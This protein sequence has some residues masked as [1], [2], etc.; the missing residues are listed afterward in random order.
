[1]AQEQTAYEGGDISVLVNVIDSTGAHVAATISTSTTRIDGFSTVPT[2]TTVSTGIY[3]INF[4]SVTPAPSEGD[5]L[6]VKVNGDISGTAWSEY[7]IP[8]KIVAD[9]RGTD[10]ASTFDAST[11]TVTTDAASRTASQA[12]VSSLA[13]SAALSG[14]ESKIDTV[15][16]NVDSILIDVGTD[17]PASIAAL[18]DF[19]PATQ[20]VTTDSASRNASKA[21][22]SSLATAASI[23][24]L[25]DISAADVWSYSTR[26][27][28]SGGITQA[29]V[30]AA[31]WNAS[32]SGYNSAGSTGKAL[33]QIKEGVISTDGSVN[34]TSATT[35]T[36]VSNLNVTTD[37]FY[38]DKIIVFISGDLLGQAR[39]IETYVG[40]TKAITVS[41][42]LTSAPQDGDE[43]LILS[44][45]SF[46]LN[47]HAE[48]VWSDTKSSYTTD[49]TFGYYLDAQVSSISAGGGEGIYTLTVTVKDADDNLISGARVNISG[50][51]NTVVSNSAGQAVFNVDSGTY[52]LVT[53]TPSGYQSPANVEVTV[54]ANASQDIVVT[55]TSAGTD[56]GWLG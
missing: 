13:T 52:T 40:S 9:E 46:S 56:A 17:I 1:M 15:D 41:V 37:G 39:H 18:N 34:D 7:G 35:T 22:V 53:S 38:H 48:A 25:N 4:A 42:P 30:A 26:T 11:D 43:F 20:E 47:E 33:R 19:D 54:S 3:R 31:V 24:A 8:V 28:T 2:V 50:T 45:Q 6:V 49:G 36:F 55:A 21:D 44:G 23:A 10:N 5:R 51:L 14:V 27:I 16:A 12:D 29:E 32:L